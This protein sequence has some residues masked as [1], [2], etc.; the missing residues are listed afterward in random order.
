MYFRIFQSV[1]GSSGGSAATYGTEI[2]LLSEMIQHDRGLFLGYI[3][4]CLLTQRIRESVVIGFNSYHLR[5]NI[6]DG[7]RRPVERFFRFIAKRTLV[8]DNSNH[9]INV[10]RF[11]SDSSS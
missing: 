1:C 11:Y 10:I 9:R 2:E 6:L 3:E 4:S 5:E 8:L 7:E